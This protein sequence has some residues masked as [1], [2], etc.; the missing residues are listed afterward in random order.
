[1]TIVGFAGLPSAGKSTMVNAIAGKRVLES[2]VCRTTT[3]PCL[4]VSRNPVL[5]ATGPN[6]HTGP[7]GPNWPKGPT[8][9]TG[10]SAV[11]WVETKLVS[12]DGVEFCALDLPGI[13]DAEDASGS[14]DAVTLEW[15]TKC[16]VVVWV[17]DARTAL[18]TKHEVAELTRLMTSIQ[19][20]ADEDGT[21]YQFTIVLAKYDE[22]ETFGV[23][24]STGPRGSLGSLG[25]R[26]SLGPIEYLPGEIRT[27]TEH[28]TIEGHLARV[29]RQF[30]GT[31]VVK[32]NAFARI[33][34]TPCSAALKALVG[35]PVQKY[36]AGLQATDFEL[37][38]ATENLTEKRLAQM[39]R[40]LRDTR[41]RLIRATEANAP[42]YDRRVKFHFAKRDT[43]S[44]GAIVPGAPLASV[45]IAFDSS[46][47]DMMDALISARLR[48][49][50]CWSGSNAGRW[51]SGV[52][53]TPS[54]VVIRVEYAQRRSI[55]QIVAPTVVRPVFGDVYIVPA[56]MWC[57]W[58]GAEVH[59]QIGEQIGIH[60][61]REAGD[62]YVLKVGE[63]AHAELH[64]L[65]LAL[66]KEP[67]CT[68]S[69]CHA[70]LVE[71]TEQ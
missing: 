30:P 15:A 42:R 66:S 14:F 34:S 29:E 7:T 67:R 36:G 6:W 55:Q 18:M 11:K 51:S 28:S 1:M 68:G 48:Y 17:T 23:G 32:F 19:E 60:T 8:V 49:N 64:S 35:P 12:D 20:K 56:V 27:E 39:S 58:K 65:A 71:V 26:G 44:V 31:R 61:G 69:G 46:I 2:G 41:L 59:G 38:W 4:V 24:R 3:E 22:P 16:D 43:V 50:H 53:Y 40:V 45:S 52:T 54:A 10:P 21:L 9:P 70:S 13:C 33:E 47:V 57:N 25:S 37:K 63:A 62:T 5:G